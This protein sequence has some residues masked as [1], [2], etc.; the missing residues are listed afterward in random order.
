MAV[1]KGKVA[2]SATQAA[3]PAVSNFMARLGCFTS[4]VIALGAISLLVRN[5]WLF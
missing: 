4:V 3:D 2:R 1:S 5:V